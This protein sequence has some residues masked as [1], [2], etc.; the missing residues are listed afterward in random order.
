MDYE[1]YHKANMLQFEMGHIRGSIERIEHGWLVFSW[2]EEHQNVID[3]DDLLEIQKEANEKVLKILK[4]QLQA[5]QDKFDK[6]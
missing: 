3:R 5:L 2:S 4:E 1:L 6:L